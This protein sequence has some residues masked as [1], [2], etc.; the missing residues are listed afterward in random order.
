MIYIKT[1]GR[2][3]QGRSSICLSSIGILGTYPLIIAFSLIL[4]KEAFKTL[5]SLITLKTRSL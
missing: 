2:P 5:E 1:Q 4:Y 3:K